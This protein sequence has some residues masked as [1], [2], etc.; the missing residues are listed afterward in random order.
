MEKELSKSALKRKERV[1]DIL[2]N[3]RLSLKERFDDI[4]KKYSPN[5]Y[6]KGEYEI[7]L[8]FIDYPFNKLDFEIEET[9]TMIIS[10]WKNEYSAKLSYLDE[11]E[12]SCK[13]IKK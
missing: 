12:Q 1:L 6:L 5:Y 8:G 2:K 13:T 7:K 4:V 10:H 11:F 9:E 3:D